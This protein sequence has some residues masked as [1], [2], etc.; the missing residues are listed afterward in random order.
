MYKANQYTYTVT[1]S[2][3]DQVFVSEVTD[4]SGIRAFG[5]SEEEALAEANKAVTLALEALASVGVDSPIPDKPPSGPGTSVGALNEL[6]QYEYKYIDTDAE[7]G[8]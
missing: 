1:W 6:G 2:Y 8:E 4:W 7:E 5:D 3:R